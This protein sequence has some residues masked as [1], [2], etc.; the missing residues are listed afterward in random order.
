MAELVV[1]YNGGTVSHYPCSD[2]L[3]LKKGKRYQVDDIIDR[4]YQTNYILR[5]IDGQFNKEWFDEVKTYLAISM[6]TPHVGKPLECTVIEKKD[7]IIRMSDVKT[8]IVNS[9]SKLT[10]N[11]FLAETATAYYI[12][13]CPLI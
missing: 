3:V 2:P 10:S 7:S 5:G 8:S 1:L 13:Q 11:T 12:V 9:S 6:A 4:G